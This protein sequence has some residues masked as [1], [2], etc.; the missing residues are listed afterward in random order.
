MD[1]EKARADG[2][3]DRQQTKCFRCGYVNNL[4]A[5]CKKP[6]KDNKKGQNTVRF[7]ERGNHTSQK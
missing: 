7:N 6:P 4:V 5:K 1:K 3:S 2:D